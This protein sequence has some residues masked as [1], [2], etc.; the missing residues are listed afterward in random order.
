M[1][2]ENQNHPTLPTERKETTNF[3]EQFYKQPDIG[4]EQATNSTQNT[5]KKSSPSY[6]CNLCSKKYTT[7]SDLVTHNKIHT[8]FNF[9][10][11]VCKRNFNMS[12]SNMISHFKLHE[13]I[14]FY[15][16]AT[17]N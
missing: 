12:Q 4:L 9:A 5:A 16:L 10:C 7:Y 15:V 17:L 2:Q 11:W 13:K 14:F 3:I 6:E 1:S 8:F